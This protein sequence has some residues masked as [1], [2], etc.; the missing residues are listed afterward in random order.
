MRGQYSTADSLASIDMH[1]G[2]S[3]SPEGSP[4]PTAKPSYMKKNVSFSEL[5]EVEVPIMPIIKS[6]EVAAERAAR[7]PED[8]ARANLARLVANNNRLCS[9][10]RHWRFLVE[11]RAWMKGAATRIRDTSVPHCGSALLVRP[12]HR[13]SR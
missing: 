10:V 1:S 13:R 8:Q 5:L 2:A 3:R 4:P 12:G 11:L 6:H 9:E 7:R